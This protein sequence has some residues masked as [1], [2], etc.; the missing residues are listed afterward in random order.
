[1]NVLI[2]TT[3]NLETQRFL[4][5]T[6]NWAAM[7]TAERTRSWVTMRH[8]CRPFSDEHSPGETL[9]I[10]QIINVHT[11][12][13]SALTWAFCI[14]LVLLGGKSQRPQFL[15]IS[16]ASRVTKLSPEVYIDVLVH[17]L[18]LIIREVSHNSSF[19]IWTVESVVKKVRI[20]RNKISE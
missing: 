3:D 19:I 1:M 6:R 9:C 13:C 16:P 5:L 14:I 4:F 8:R 15:Y 7:I 18:T 10:I 17:S 11:V 12:S 20:E 2:D